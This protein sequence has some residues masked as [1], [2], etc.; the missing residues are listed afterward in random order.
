MS[1]YLV[2]QGDIVAAT[3][4]EIEVAFGVRPMANTFHPIANP[5]QETGGAADKSTGS[6]AM[7]QKN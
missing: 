2:F 1:P 4:P 5:V 3:P 6:Y 7:T